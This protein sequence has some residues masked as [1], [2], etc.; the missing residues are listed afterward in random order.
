MPIAAA[1]LAIYAGLSLLPQLQ[2]SA[3]HELN[4][5][6]RNFYGVISVLEREADDPDRRTI[7]FY[8][9]RIVHG[10]QF[11]DAK[12]KDEPTAYFGRST[13]VG[14]ALG[15]LATRPGAR[16]GIVGLGIGTMAAY[17]QPGQYYRF[18]EIN[19]EVL[20]F[21]EQYFTY[22]D[23]CRGHCEV[24]LGDARLS[25]EQE[26]PQQFDLLI[27]DAFSGDAVPVH[28][29]T[30]EAFEIY[31]RHLQPGASV[32]INISNRYLDLSPVIAGLADHFGYQVQRT[33]SPA[34]PELGQFPADWIVL[35]PNTAAPTEH[36][37]KTSSTTTGPLP[38]RRILWTDD[39]SNLFEILK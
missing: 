21:A 10:L 30:A 6:A 16:V 20:R 8:S 11:T 24:K 18:Y 23:D 25:L 34:V 4:A 29:L 28:L 5:S 2:A 27:L 12:K 39:F 22:L 35:S 3:R 38:E 17:A 9:G 33:Y 13:G 19:N 15:Q 14:Q 32:A 26:P 37:V 36:E 7:N 31:R 1:L